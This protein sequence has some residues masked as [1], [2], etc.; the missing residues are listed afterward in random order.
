MKRGFLQQSAKRKR[1]VDVPSIAQCVAR[2]EKTWADIVKAFC[3]EF[4]MR[5][6]HLHGGQ[7]C[8]HAEQGARRVH[9]NSG[10]VHITYDETCAF[11]ERMQNMPFSAC[12]AGRKE[13]P[14]CKTCAIR[15]NDMCEKRREMSVKI[16]LEA[17]TFR[18][19]YGVQRRRERGV[20]A[21]IPPE[22]AQ[23]IYSFLLHKLDDGKFKPLVFVAC[24]DH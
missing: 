9:V 4:I 19:M 20:F 3:P 13:L 14:W 17:D 21:V 16:T 2:D 15:Y 18:L 7:L 6:G 22:V 1:K 8:W 10:H 12:I 24:S 11:W 23:H 5:H